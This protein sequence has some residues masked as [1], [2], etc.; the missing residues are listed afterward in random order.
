MY[1]VDATAV[2]VAFP[3]FMRELHTNVLWAG[4][5]ISIYYIG[6]TIA[7]PLAGSL[8]DTFGRKRVFI[9]SLLFFTGSSLACGFA[10]NIYM[11]IAFRFFQGIGGASFFPTAS[12]MVSDYFP[13]SRQTA[14][15]LFSSIFPIGGIIGPNVGGWIVSRYSWRYIFY[16]NLPVGIG[17][18]L[19]IMVLLRDSKLYS[20]PRVDIA[21]ALLMSAAILLLM[22]GLNLMGESLSLRSAW[23]G[24]ALLASSATLVFLFLGHEKKQVN[25]IL[26]VVLLRSRPFLAANLLNMALG[27]GFFGLFSFVP[28]YVTSVYHLSTLLSGMILTP[29]S[30]G[31]L[32]ASTITS[33]LLRRYGYRLP[34]VCGLV[35]VSCATLLFVP[36]LL[37]GAS[38]TQLSILKVL[39]VLMLVSGIGAGITNPAANNASIELMPGKIATIMGLRGMFRTVGGALGISLITCILH[40]S[41]SRLV[42]F[43]ITFALFG[44]VLASVIPLVFLIPTGKKAFG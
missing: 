4:W 25:P 41:S 36:G 29:R 14:I 42:G 3:H 5:T 1:M 37:L 6:V 21:G 22:F 44:F 28:L 27:A 17:L 30:L 26:D 35:V 33:F 11:L 15:G 32:A 13:E 12:G 23:L 31:V 19:V 43:G 34:L 10:V 38:G 7:T 9:V 16:I 40:L 2:A 20:R 8:S 18:L 24:A 39:S